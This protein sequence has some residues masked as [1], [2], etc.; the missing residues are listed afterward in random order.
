MFFLV[1]IPFLFSRPAPLS[2]GDPAP[3][4]SALDQEG[5]LLDLG[6]IFAQGLTLVFFF[7][8]ADTPGCTAQG[9]S[10]RDAFEDLTRDGLAILGVSGD[11]PAA[12]KKFR[13]KFRLPYPLVADFEGRVAEAFG[14]PTVLGMPARRAFL[15]RDGRLVWSVRRAKTFGHADEARQAVKKLL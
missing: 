7:P 14:V 6:R 2:V 15:I 12:Q 8:K 1:K 10:L 11:R 13:E 4:I 3:K 5:M 9:C